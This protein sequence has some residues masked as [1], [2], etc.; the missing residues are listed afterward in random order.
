MRIRS[1]LA[2]AM[3]AA[4]ALSASTASAEVW[5][6]ASATLCEACAGHNVS[7]NFE[8]TDGASA[9]G[10]LVYST[11]PLQLNAKTGRHEGVGVFDAKIANPDGTD[12]IIARDVLADFSVVFGPPGEGCSLPT[13]Q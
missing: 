5:N 13:I 10:V 7:L 9:P 3:M 1:A 11:S 4:L 2:L 6:I 8:S 12:T